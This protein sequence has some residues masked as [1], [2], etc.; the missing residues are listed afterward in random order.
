MIIDIH[1]HPVLYD[2]INPDDETLNFRKQ[3][4]GVYKSGRVPLDFAIRLMDDAGIDKTVILGEDYSSEGCRALVSNSE[5][6]AVVN[7]APNRFIG[8]AGADP[9]RADAPETLE[10]AFSELGLSG[11]YLNLSRLH[12]YP[13][14]PRLEPL[15]KLCR[16]M[17]RPVIF[18]GG[19]SWIPDSPAKY[20][21]PVRFE[22]IACS[23]PELKI[24]LAHLGWPWHMETIMMLMKY[25]NVYTDTS[26]IYMGTSTQYY[27]QIFCR[28]MDINWLQNSF[29]DKVMFGSDL[30]RWR[31]VRS[32][33]GL[34]KLPVRQDVL[35]KI[36]G[37]NAEE[38]LGWRQRDER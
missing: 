32:M 35:E 31:Q 20:S 5:I 24:C 12:I 33:E 26:L 14:D 4:F 2:V 16:D 3:Q 10:K 38:F 28:E 13:D 18:N 36:L 21:E 17:D 1:A 29:A 8:F 34:K 9:R 22:D 15:M 19:Y 37:Q 23:F 25:P 7:A 11:L 6:R 30:P 27:E